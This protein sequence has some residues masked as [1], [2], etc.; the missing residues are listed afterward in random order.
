VG[1]DVMRESRSKIFVGA[2]LPFPTW[3]VEAVDHVMDRYNAKQHCAS[4]STNSAVVP[5]P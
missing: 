5:E 3:I 2:R 1:N 4:V